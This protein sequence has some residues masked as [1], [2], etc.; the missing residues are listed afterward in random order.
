M[1]FYFF[2]LKIDFKVTFL[3]QAFFFH[4]IVKGLSE[5]KR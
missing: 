1:K 2:F 5:G 4:L 3:K